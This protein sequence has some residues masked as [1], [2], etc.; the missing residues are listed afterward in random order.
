MIN[1][2]PST[3]KGMPLSDRILMGMRKAVRQLVEDRAAKDK[4]LVVEV[5]GEIKKVPA[6][7]LLKSLPQ[8]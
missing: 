4:S 2:D 3:L 6:K 5:E 7:E 8:E 1:I